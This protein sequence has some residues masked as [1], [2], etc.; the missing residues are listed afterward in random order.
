MGLPYDAT[1]TVQLL[2]IAGQA[3]RTEYF[4]GRNQRLSIPTAK[5]AEGMYILQIKGEDITISKK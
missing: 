1:M 2:N 3:V 4:D 5:I